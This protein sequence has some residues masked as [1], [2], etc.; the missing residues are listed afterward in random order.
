[1]KSTGDALVSGLSDVAAALTAASAELGRLFTSAS[2]VLSQAEA[3]LAVLCAPEDLALPLLQ[4]SSMQFVSVS[5]LTA[6]LPSHH[7]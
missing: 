6:P 2:D 7:R 4:Q 1:M 5:L 3:T